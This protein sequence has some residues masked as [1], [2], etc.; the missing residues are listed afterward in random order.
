MTHVSS[1]S[2]PKTQQPSS[3][4]EFF[5]KLYGDLEDN[6]QDRP[7]S[8]IPKKKENDLIAPVPILATPLPFLFPHGSESPLAVAAAGLSAFRK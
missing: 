2:K 6:S 3:P 1:L 4:R 8:S 7:E 5:Q